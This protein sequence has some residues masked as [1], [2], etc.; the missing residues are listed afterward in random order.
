MRYIFAYN[1]LQNSPF[2]Q[3]YLSG[4]EGNEV[5]DVPPG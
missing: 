3:L 5:L 1:E 4:C 2:L